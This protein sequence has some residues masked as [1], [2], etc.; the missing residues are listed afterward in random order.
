[1]LGKKTVQALLTRKASG[2]QSFEDLL[3]ELLANLTGEPYYLSSSGW[4]GG[5]DGIAKGRAIGF[6][7]KRYGET[8]LDV[9]SLIGE[10][11]QATRERPD[12]QL[13]ILATTGDLTAQERRQLEDSAADHGLALLTLAEGDLSVPFH[14]LAGLC[15]VEPERV[16]EVLLD[17][18]WHDPKK[19]VAFSIDEIRAELETIAAAPEFASFRIG[20]EKEL[21]ELPTWKIF[22]QR[23]NQ[24]LK[25]II[26]EAS[27]V[28]LGTDF[29]RDRVIPR[30]VKAE[31]DR[32]LG[33]AS[34]S[35]EPHLGTILGERFDGKTWVVFDWLVDHLDSLDMPVFFLGSN[36]GDVPTRLN[37]LLTSLIEE[38]LG[39]YKRHATALLERHRRWS[40]GRTPWCL[41]I[42][43]G[44]NEYRGS[45]L[46][47]MRH[48][49][50][51]FAR[52]EAERRPAAVLC[53]VRAKA[54]P[55]IHKEVGRSVK[56]QIQT[57][58]V[59]PFD[60]VEFVEALR[61]AGKAHDEISGFP[62]SAQQL[63]HRPRFFQLVLDHRH[64]LGNFE[65]INE[66]VLYWL[67]AGDKLRRERAPAGWTEERFQ[68]VLIDLAPK[69][70]HRLSHADVLGSLGAQIDSA[71]SALDDLASEGVLEKKGMKY[72]V[73]PD[74]LRT[75]MALCL[76]DRLDDPRAT[77]EEL[78]ERL[79]D[80]L[81][82]HGDDDMAAAWLRRASVFAL[83]LEEQP[84]EEVIDVLVDEWLRSRNRS[85]D[86]LEQMKSL[87][88]LLLRPLL[89]LAP[90]AWMRSTRHPG[91]QELS[92]LVFSEFLDREKDLIRDSLRTWC[93]FVPARGPGFMDDKPDIEQKVQ[94]ALQDPGLM[95]SGLQLYGDSGLLNLQNV[96]LYMESL[97]PGLLAAD[98]LLAILM[99][100]HIH[101]YYLSGAAPWV[102]RRA[103]A[104]VPREWFEEWTRR[105]AHHQGSRLREVVHHLLLL[106]KRADLDDLLLLVEPELT[107]EEDRSRHFRSLDRAGYDDVRLT[108]FEDE[109]KPILFLKRVRSLV[110]DPDL[111]PPGNERLAAIR[112]A[113]QE[114]FAGVAL[115][116]DRTSSRE[117]H[118]FRD[119]LAAIAAWL[120]EEGAA[121]VYRQI[122]DLPRRFREGEHWWV[123]S[124]RRHAVLAE[125]QARDHLR[126]GAQ[127]S[128]PDDNGCLAPGY[129]LLTLLPGMTPAD[130]VQAILHHSLDFEWSKFYD[131][132]RWLDVEGMR[133]S[134]LAVLGK[135]AAPRER[136][137]AY[138]LLP[139]LG[140]PPTDDDLFVALRKDIEGDDSQLRSGALGVAVAFEVPGLPPQR[141]LTLALDKE[142]NQKTFAPRYAA[143]LLIQGGHFLDRLPPYWRAI[144]AAVHPAWREPLLQEVESALCSPEGEKEDLASDVTYTLPF[145]ENLKPGRERLSLQEE[146]RTLYFRQPQSGMGGFEEGASFK[147]LKEA[148]IG[149][150]QDLHIEKWNR[151]I[152]EGAVEFRRRREE[153]RTVW[154]TEQFPQELVDSLETSRFERWAEVLLRDEQKTWFQW[155]GLVI[156]C[157]RRALRRGHPAAAR[158]WDLVNPLPHR[159]K[160]GGIFYLDRGIDWVFHE[161]SRTQADDRIA[162]TFLNELIMD[163]RADRQLFDIAL[164]AR[165]RD[166]ARL[167]MVLDDLLKSQDFEDR[168]RTAKVL[169]WVEG[170]EERLQLLIEGDPSLWVR[171]IAEQ[172]L[173]ARQRE[174]FARHWLGRFL[175]QDLTRVQRW[176]A[177]QLFLEVVDGSF[178]AWSYHFVQETALDVRSRGEA[179]LLLD[180]ARAEVKRR[181]SDALEKHFLGYKVIDLENGSY[182]WRR[183]RSWTE[184]EERF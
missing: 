104:D 113:W 90:R 77:R 78:R 58:D 14:P 29:D 24:R 88:K 23:Q 123:L 118:F 49:S 12:L 184:I 154:S 95:E 21:R 63:L 69:A 53:T 166:Q 131:F 101:F 35:H 89:R 96:V 66:D 100:Q 75:G 62:Q 117:E 84:R 147:Q 164:G 70:R 172:S 115:Q 51:A 127:T 111:P 153:H 102:L 32:W 41:L 20:L 92:I 2:P 148:L 98:D 85:P 180:E 10:I 170:S 181:R 18:V 128:C 13:W 183:Q 30:T 109:E 52:A 106:A 99:V 81:A 122:E 169:G 120:P 179:V 55:E 167:M 121:V 33:G 142:E 173:K 107:Q 68:D 47:W 38:A 39:P 134:T 6:E 97:F 103:F 54:W 141:L 34:T 125:E 114:M 80:V 162:R 83:L 159:Q 4:Q 65:V 15:A 177:G 42:L 165:C 79:R 168:A 44:L 156:P 16:C 145:R 124:I 149:D 178:E 11:D 86:D 76:L 1:M 152:R 150:F 50:D 133:E 93:R 105:A 7:A 82:P 19:D 25:R 175:R 158:L 73:R 182:P 161:L 87:G 26:L 64:R 112:A 139:E 136:V 108:P 71:L 74:H 163:A 40:A 157:F 59:G 45:P 48:L 91:L 116:L 144:A 37:D 9:R 8:D 151:L 137:R 61:R 138:F 27:K 146:D 46:P 130:A 43:D 119:D 135:E 5:I 140:N 31:L 171:Q 36:Q 56:P 72:A 17:P 126:A 176:G 22:V 155:I 143:W 94:E 110:I 67:D 174:S 129:A 57:L 28:E 132:A 60:D 160:P 3:R